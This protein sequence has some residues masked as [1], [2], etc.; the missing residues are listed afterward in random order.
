M[1]RSSSTRRSTSRSR[2]TRSSDRAEQRDR[3][4]ERRARSEG[5]ARHGLFSA[6]FIKILLKFLPNEAFVAD[7]AFD[8]FADFSESVPRNILMNGQSCQLIIARQEL[9]QL[10][11]ILRR[12]RAKVRC[13]VRN[14]LVT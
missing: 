8:A 14:H 10:V 4:V 13:E 5:A 2:R 12:E 1:T 3:D 6:I 11:A 7:D 9:L